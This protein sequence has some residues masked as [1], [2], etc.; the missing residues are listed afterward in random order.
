MLQ[1]LTTLAK[2]FATEA[3]AAPA[4]STTARDTRTSSNQFNLQALKDYMESNKADTATE[5]EPTAIKPGPQATRAET[6]E[7]HADRVAAET[8][9]SVAK[10]GTTDNALSWLGAALAAAKRPGRDSAELAALHA[11]Q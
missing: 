9:A 7:Q 1:A 4:E 5:A 3:P 8:E 11:A 10:V 6:A 2:P